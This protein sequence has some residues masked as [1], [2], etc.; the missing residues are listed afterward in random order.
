MQLF[1]RVRLIS[2]EVARSQSELAQRI[3]LTL[4]TF[5]GYLNEKRQDN[6]W[7]VLPKILENYPQINRMWLYFGEGEMVRGQ[8]PV[9]AREQE[10]RDRITVLEQEKEVLNGELAEERR[11]TRQLT[12]RLL[13]DGVG[14][15][16]AAAGIGKAGEGHE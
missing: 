7:P 1:E 16:G 3:G 12:T 10:L 6:L 5:N 8:E 2:A 15:K 9:S 14:D 4:S 13:V 11:L